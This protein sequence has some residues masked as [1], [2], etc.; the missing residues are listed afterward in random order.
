MSDKKEEIKRKLNTQ[1]QLIYSK[2]LPYFVL[3]AL[4]GVFTGAFIFLFKVVTSYIMH[5]SASIYAFVREEPIYLPLLILGVAAIGTAS[6]LILKYAKECRGGGIP[7]AIASIRG[8]IPL[9]WIQGVFV[10]FTSSCMTYLAGVPLGNEGPSVQMGCAIGK[11]SSELLGKKKRAYERYIMTGGACSG[12]AVATGAPISGILFALEETH[13]KFSPVLFIVAAVSVLSGTVT[14]EFLSVC[15]S[16]DTTFF[17]LTIKEIL[18]NRNLWI[19]GV[20]GAVCGFSA[21]AFTNLYKFVKKLEKNALKKLPRVY[22]I[23][24]IFIL[25]AIIGFVCEDFIGS[26]HSVIEKIFYG[27]MIWYIILIAFLVRAVVMI[28][29][30]SEGVSG[31]IFIPTLA[32]GAMIAALISKAF[33]AIGWF[34]EKYF[35]ILVV[36]GMVSFLSASSRTPITALTFAAEALCVASNI[37]PV[38]VG[39]VVSYLIVEISGKI[40]YTD[41]VIESRAEAAHRDKLPIII[42]THISVKHGAFAVGME[43]RDLLLPPTCAVLSVDS[44]KSDAPKHHGALHE[45]DVLHIHYQTYNVK[46]TMQILTQIFGPQEQDEAMKIHFGSDLHIV[47]LE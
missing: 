30:N 46:D 18:P 28:F 11:G 17:D 25:T 33:I 10:L 29:A 15:F 5:L 13:R 7:T 36:V 31:G 43:I 42:D 19:A 14:Q 16:V 1:K 2:F 24:A 22:K 35:A 45:G 26:G 40:A 4:I 34:D 39:V 6:A 23:I 12:F 32:F 41:T 38:V 8:L 20:I 27:E 37:L 44:E 9:K 3:P 21:I 47:P